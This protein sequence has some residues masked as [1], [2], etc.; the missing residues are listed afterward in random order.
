[1]TVLLSPGLPRSV[2]DPNAASQAATS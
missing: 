1:V 2:A